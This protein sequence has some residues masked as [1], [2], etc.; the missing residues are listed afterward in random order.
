MTE[1]FMTLW[2]HRDTVTPVR[3]NAIGQVSKDHILWAKSFP[4][5]IKIGL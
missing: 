3:L 2:A 5:S 1:M 4:D